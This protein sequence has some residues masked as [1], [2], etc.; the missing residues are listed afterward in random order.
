M[1]DIGPMIALPIH[2]KRFRP[3][4]LPHRYEEDRLFQEHD[5]GRFTEP[6]G[7]D[8]TNPVTGSKNQINDMIS[9]PC[10]TDP[11][12]KTDF[13]MIPPFCKN[14]HQWFDILSMHEHIEIFGSMYHAGITFQREGP[15]D[16]KRNSRLLY[17]SQ[18]LSI[19]G[20]ADMVG[21]LCQ[22]YLDSTDFN[23]SCKTRKNGCGQSCWSNSERATLYTGIPDPIRPSIDS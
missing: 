16:Q 7:I 5:L 14:L 21:E 4:H 9:L 17:G 18:D 15:T 3:D 10:L 8:G 2:D 19:E 20:C 23:G 11:M 1:G 22:A 6:F 12:G 13:R